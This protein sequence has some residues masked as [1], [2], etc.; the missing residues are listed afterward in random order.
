[1][2]AQ[3][4]NQQ[5]LLAGL[6]GRGYVLTHER[7]A[8]QPVGSA[9]PATPQLGYLVLQRL[10]GLEIAVSALARILDGAGFRASQIVRPSR[11]VMAGWAIDAWSAA[12]ADRNRASKVRRNSRWDEADTRRLQLGTVVTSPAGRTITIIAQR[13]DEGGTRLAEVY[14]PVNLLVP[15]GTGDPELR[16][17]GAAD[18]DL[19]PFDGRDLSAEFLPHWRAA[20]GIC[21]T[22]QIR[23][24]LENLTA[25]MDE[26]P[27]PALGGVRFIPVAHAPRLR[28]VVGVV[29]AIA[30]GNAGGVATMTLVPLANDDDTRELVRE[31]ASDVSRRQLAEIAAKIAEL[32]VA[33]RDATYERRLAELRDLLAQAKTY[34]QVAGLDAQTIVDRARALQV[35]VADL[36]RKHRAEAA[37]RQ[38][39]GVAA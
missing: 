39:Q 22:E 13:G 3:G 7:E 11:D 35:E 14:N 12:Q 1:M 17:N 9:A 6:E 10:K 5:H 28:A 26:L 36:Q 16:L 15:S 2:A 8:G 27:L 18:G 25:G 32:S 23:Q 20:A 31:T 34:G 29:R 33:S 24:T 21:R 19:T 38:P 4:W 37:A 30:T